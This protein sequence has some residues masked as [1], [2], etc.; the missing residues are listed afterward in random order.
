MDS[1]VLVIVNVLLFLGSWSK[2]TH[3]YTTTH[4]FKS[5]SV[6]TKPGS[7]F[8]A[9]RK[10]GSREGSVFFKQF[11]KGIGIEKCVLKSHYMSSN[12]LVNGDSMI[13]KY[14]EK[15]SVDTALNFKINNTLIQKT[16]SS[17]NKVFTTRT[18]D[19]GSKKTE[20]MT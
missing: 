9:H 13:L 10:E 4:S 1:L 7:V 5:N 17:V 15:D 16:T 2:R 6:I 19:N 14:Y 12:A 8:K 3:K 20:L 18:K 11:G